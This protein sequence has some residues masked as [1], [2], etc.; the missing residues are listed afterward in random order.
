MQQS[1]DQAHARGAGPAGVRR[2]R[3]P[4]GVV[5]E[6][7][8]SI[9][10]EAVNRLRGLILSKKCRQYCEKSKLFVVAGMIPCSSLRFMPG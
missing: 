2:S 6:R 8:P 4:S 5:S 1:I 3:V 9:K 7:W 10:W